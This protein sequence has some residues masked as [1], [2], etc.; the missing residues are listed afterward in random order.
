VREGALTAQPVGGIARGT[1]E[2]AVGVGADPRDGHEGGGCLG[3]ER[4]GSSCSSSVALACVRAGERRALDMR[5]TC[6]AA[7]GMEDVTMPAAGRVDRSASRVRNARML[8]QGGLAP[9]HTAVVRAERDE[10]RGWRKDNEG[11]DA[12]EQSKRLGAVAARGARTRR[13]VE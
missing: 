13:M 2:G 11:E 8:V 1:E 9:L 3:D 12:T 4:V 6:V 5:A 10:R 7:S